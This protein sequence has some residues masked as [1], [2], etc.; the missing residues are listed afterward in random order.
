M[1][2]VIGPVGVGVGLV[3]VV[4]TAVD[5]VVVELPVGAV[6]DIVVELTM[7][8]LYMFS[9]LGPPQYSVEFALQV[10][11]HIVC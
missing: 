11:S 1:P 9:L 3:A 6:V 10:M 4:V 7:V 5:A 2:T 8:R